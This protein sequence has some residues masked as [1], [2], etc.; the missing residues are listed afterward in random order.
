MKRSFSQFNNN[1]IQLQPLKYR[2]LNNNNRMTMDMNN[3]NILRGEI[4]EM[5]K[6]IDL[7]KREMRELK[8]MIKEVRIFVG[9]E[10]KKFD[11]ECSYIS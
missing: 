1:N 10:Y 5:R 8:D 11:N 3:I 2:K 4:Y 9:M 7:I 6:D